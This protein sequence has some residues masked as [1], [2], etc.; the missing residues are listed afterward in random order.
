MEA[1]GEHSLIRPIETA[2]PVTEVSLF[3]GEI[4]E[5]TVKEKWKR[6]LVNSGK[7]KSPIST[8]MEPQL[9]IIRQHPRRTILEIIALQW[10][11]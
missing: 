9:V 2:S 8:A 1:G 10:K 11:I 3:Q 7:C 5:S 6:P 4:T